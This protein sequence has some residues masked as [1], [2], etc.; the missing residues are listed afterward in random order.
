MPLVS[1]WEALSLV[2]E[3]NVAGLVTRKWDRRTVKKPRMMAKKCK[4]ID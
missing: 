4:S 3:R 1:K 2:P